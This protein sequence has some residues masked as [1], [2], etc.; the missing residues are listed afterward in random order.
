MANIQNRVRNSVTVHHAEVN[1]PNEIR[2]V[3]R[4]FIEDEDQIANL[5][6]K[7]VPDLKMRRQIMLPLDNSPENMVSLVFSRGAK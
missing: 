5:V 4:D 7:F 1:T 2:D 3:L 6:K